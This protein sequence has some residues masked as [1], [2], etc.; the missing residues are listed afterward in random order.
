MFG[1][2]V[3]NGPPLLGSVFNILGAI[4][5]FLGTYY[6]LQYRRIHHPGRKRQ[7]RQRSTAVFL[8][9][10]LFAYATT[11]FFPESGS[12]T[13]RIG[14]TIQG[15]FEEMSIAFEADTTGVDRSM[16]LVNRLERLIKFLGLSVYIV[17]FV[18]LSIPMK[19][20]AKFSKELW[21]RL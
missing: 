2:A 6:Y 17:L 8:L 14:M 16:T 11:Q 21:Q 13:S 4:L 1:Q 10:F 5:I 18:L 20:T 15:Y 9:F 3:S 19:M 12:W 7:F